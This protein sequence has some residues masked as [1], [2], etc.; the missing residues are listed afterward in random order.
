MALLGSSPL[1]SIYVW[2]AFLLL[3]WSTLRQPMLGTKLTVH[4]AF[5]GHA[6]QVLCIRPVYPSSC[7]LACQAV[8]GSAL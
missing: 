5:A 2:V 1:S 8:G 4:A 3:Q 7:G 6:L